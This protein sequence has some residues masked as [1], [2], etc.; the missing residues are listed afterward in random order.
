M[1]IDIE[2]RLADAIEKLRNMSIEDV[3]FDGLDPV[4]KMM[5]VALLNETQKIQ[6]SIDGLP[7][8]IVERFCSDFIPYEATEAVPAIV[9]INPKFK[10]QKEY[11]IINV[12]TGTTFSYTY[13]TEKQKLSLN[14]LP[15]FNTLLIPFSELY[16]LTPQRLSYSK[17]TRLIK[18]NDKN[19][20]WVGISTE[21][22]LE[23][24][25]GASLLI[26]GV[27]IMPEHF[28]IG[29]EEREIDFTTMREVECLDFA[30]PF[31]AQQS[32]GQFFSIIQV[33]KE[34]MLNME[35]S[36]LIYLTDKV[37]DRDLF[38]PCAYPRVFQQWLEDEDLDCFDTNTLW[39]QIVF[40]KEFSVPDTFEIVLN[41]LPVVNV[42]VN[43]VT[44]TQSSPIAK[45][46][47]QED[48]FFLKILE[49]SSSSHKQGYSMTADEIIVRDF[50]ASCYHNGNLYRDVRTLYNRFIDDYY[51]FIEYNGIRDGEVLKHLRETINK[52]GKSVGEENNKY[53]FDS[54]TYVMKKMNQS[55]QSSS[56]K[57][58]YL[59]TRGGIGNSPQ[60]GQLME[61]KKQPPGIEQKAEVVISGMGGADK[62]SVDARYEQLRYYALTNDRLYTKMDVE[63]FIRK[64]IVV[65]FGREEARRIFIQIKIEGV[66]GEYSLRRGLY[67]DVE[68]KDKK[69]YEKAKNGLF[70]KITLQKL[71]EK[72]CISMP[73]IVELKNMEE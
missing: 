7:L 12:G 60:K 44:L 52:V 24:I 14:Y 62:V 26:S 72:S 63:A 57:V 67:I 70:D 58:S 50:D 1:D 71:R 66:G 35:N 16:V 42:D 38:K 41:V 3:D 18:M 4:S 2:K 59:T 27:N 39:L 64:E 54:G 8:Q 31:D 73:I 46:Q 20:V 36:Y 69:N 25:N 19:C 61:S 68:F 5:L 23:R 33:W 49:T 37:Q 13:K 65:A 10:S 56:I 34:K 53:R 55:T 21:T 30:E 47:K 48:S 51:A 9:L 15:L 32:S 28:Y 11:D 43:N 17:G 6:D 45:L 22:E 40:P 29:T